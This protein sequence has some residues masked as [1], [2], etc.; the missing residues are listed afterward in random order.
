MFNTNDLDKKAIKTNSFSENCTDKVKKK[1]ITVVQVNACLDLHNLNLEN[2]FKTLVSFIERAYVLNYKKILVITGKGKNSQNSDQTIKS[3][4]SNWLC[5][6]S[7][8]K[9]INKFSTASRKD[10]GEGAY[11]IFLNKK[12]SGSN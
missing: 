4:F 3:E 6:G 9:M 8:K 10:G 5:H 1:N 7:I 12:L 11:Y 2:A